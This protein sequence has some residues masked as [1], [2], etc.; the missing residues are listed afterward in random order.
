MMT[1]DDVPRFRFAPSPTGALHVGSLHTALFNWAL[2]RS[3]G[4]DFILRIDDTDAARN[5]EH[6]IGEIMDGLQWLGL[7]WDEGPDIGGEFGPYLQSLRRD[8]H[9]EI[10][11]QLY[12][13][14]AAYYGEEGGEDQGSDSSMPLRLRLPQ[15]GDM[16]F[17]DLL[18]GSIRFQ[19]AQLTD[20]VIV[21]SDGSPLYHLATV[22]DDHDMAISY[23]ARGEDWIA[24]TPLHEHLYRLLEWEP[25]KWIHLPLIRDPQGGKL[26][27]RDEQGGYLVDDFQEQ[28]YLAEAL[29]NYL[30]LLGW[31]PPG[32]DELVG[33]AHV[34][35]LLRAEDLS[36]SPAMFDWDRLNWFNRRYLQQHGDRQLAQLV[37]PFLE[38]AYPDTP[39]D[40]RWLQRL[41]ALLRDELVRLADAVDA[42]EW[43]FGD[44]FSL[45]EEA[46]RALQGVSTRPVLV[47]F[48][49]EL[50]H[51]VLLDEQSAQTI[52]QQLQQ[53]FAA[54]HGWRAQDIYW[55]IRAALTGRV[56]GPA[57]HEL[58]A[59][60]GKD[61]CLQRAA[62]ILRL[63]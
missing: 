7:D 5:K 48:I 15:D 26:S 1:S 8:R 32:G 6:L 25:P 21:R 40:E 16:A 43:A 35:R 49:A 27:K 63:A 37:R 51:I 58:M 3:M 57:L 13:R 56:Q 24:S 23:V 50:A 10:A 33:K 19:W 62:A 46:Q 60:L 14:G 53:R 9:I 55:P 11:A 17:D 41:V 52:L 54:S 42:S 29:F 38:D 44:D 28:G 39:L 22:V 36:P 45:S 61:A 12:D 59:L 2:A 30:L 34:R 47:H 31:A 20:P 4:G 18:R